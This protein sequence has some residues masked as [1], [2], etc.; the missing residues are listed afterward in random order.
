M[1]KWLLFLITW[2]TI[3]VSF[4][5]AQ[6]AQLE[7]SYHYTVG[8]YGHQY[9]NVAEIY[10][11]S[12]GNRAYS[13]R[14][15]YTDINKTVTENL[16]LNVRIKDNMIRVVPC[17]CYVVDDFKGLRYPIF[18]D[19][20]RYIDDNRSL[21]VVDSP[22]TGCGYYQFD[23]IP[24]IYGYEFFYSLSYDVTKYSEGGKSIERHQKECRVVNDGD[25]I[26]NINW[27]P[28]LRDR[29]VIG[30]YAE[31]SGDRCYWDIQFNVFTEGGKI[32]AQIRAGYTVGA[33][34]VELH[35]TSYKIQVNYCGRVYWLTRDG[36][37]SDV[38]SYDVTETYTFSTDL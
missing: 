26:Y 8:G 24:K 17:D 20:I 21:E 19:N 3:C 38:N 16:N 33:H 14:Q 28:D 27:N 30:S 1:R 7:V 35:I 2:F 10:T 36:V 11:V 9:S 31:H 32:Y 15:T 6:A 25:V 5:A 23:Y 13:E 34:D 18:I 29:I 22:A 37:T 12:S 4:H